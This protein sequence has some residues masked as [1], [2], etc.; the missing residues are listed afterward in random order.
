[1]KE[2]I[3]REL[4]VAREKGDKRYEEKLLSSYKKTYG[5]DYT[6]STPKKK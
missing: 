2:T 3:V 4:K 1:M 5:E 6:E